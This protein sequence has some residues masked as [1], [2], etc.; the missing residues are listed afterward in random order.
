MKTL[1]ETIDGMTALLL[2]GECIDLSDVVTS[3]RHYLKE[4]QAEKG[5]LANARAL[6]E[7][8]Y[9]KHTRWIEN[10]KKAYDKYKSLELGLIHAHA[11]LLDNPALT[12]DELKGMEGKPV[13][14]ETFNRK[15]GRWVIFLRT[16]KWCVDP[17]EVAIFSNM[18]RGG[19]TFYRDNY[20]KTWQAYRKE[21]K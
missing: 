5:S 15:D 6:T 18:S 11:D 7:E 20:G 19:S 1:E 16:R 14:V 9:E 10:C 12:W 3:A 4:Y 17:C 2:S 21:R 8:A 13:W